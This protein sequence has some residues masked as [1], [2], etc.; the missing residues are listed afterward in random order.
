MTNHGEEAGVEAVQVGPW[1]L[2]I[3]KIDLGLESLW[4]GLGGALPHVQSSEQDQMCFGGLR[5]SYLSR[6]DGWPAEFDQD[7]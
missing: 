6:V 2:A 1:P 4:V 5:T 3:S 7:G